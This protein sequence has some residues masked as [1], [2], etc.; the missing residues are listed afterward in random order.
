MVDVQKI[1]HPTFTKTGEWRSAK[2]QQR[3]PAEK[4]EWIWRF[5][6]SHPP[7]WALGQF[8]KN[9]EIPYETHGFEGAIS[10]VSMCTSS[11]TSDFERVEDIGSW[12]LPQLLRRYT[13]PQ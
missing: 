12:E 1:K 10:H 2:G 11:A 9:L 13:I 8:P 6:F 4:P 3:G 7:I 5:L